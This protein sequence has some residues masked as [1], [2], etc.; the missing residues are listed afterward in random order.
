VEIVKRS[1]YAKGFVVLPRTGWSNVLSH[2][3]VAVADWQGISKRQSPAQLP[4]HSS[5]TSAS[6]QDGSQEL[7]INHNHYESDTKRPL[8][9]V[10]LPSCPVL[11]IALDRLF[12]LNSVVYGDQ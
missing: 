3:S 5:L 2:G 10:V 4:G 9:A 7:E 8:R 12:R 11:S 1:D 6:S